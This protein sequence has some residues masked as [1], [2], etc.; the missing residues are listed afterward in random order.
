MRCAWCLPTPMAEPSV[1]AEA[2]CQYGW[3]GWG[4]CWGSCPGASGHPGL[5]RR[6]ASFKVPP[7]MG[8]GMDEASSVF[9]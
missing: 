9:T 7:E 5:T 8:P 4:L 1:G 2:G 6:W 3:L